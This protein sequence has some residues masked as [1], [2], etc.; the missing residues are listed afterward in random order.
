MPFIVIELDCDSRPVEI[1]SKNE[2]LD[3][4]IIKKLYNRPDDLYVGINKEL[5]AYY[6]YS[7]TRAPVF[8]MFLS[9]M[10]RCL[11]NIQF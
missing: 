3:D 8:I 6:F 5:G 2:A 9:M 4:V 7:N 10:E 11:R 1:L